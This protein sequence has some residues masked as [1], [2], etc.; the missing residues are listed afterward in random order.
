[1]VVVVV[2]DDDDDV[3]HDPTPS[4]YKGETGSNSRQE[5]DGPTVA[6]Y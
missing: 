4:H 5:Q 1:L 6:L 3:L 2:V